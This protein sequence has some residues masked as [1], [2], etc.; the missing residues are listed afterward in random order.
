MLHQKRIDRPLETWGQVPFGYSRLFSL[1]KVSLYSPGNAG[2][3]VLHRAKKCKRYPGM[4][5]ALHPRKNPEKPGD[6]RHDKLPKEEQ[7]EKDEKQ[8]VAFDPILY[9]LEMRRD[10][11]K[12]D[13]GAVERRDRNEIEN[14][15]AYVR[16]D[17]KHGNFKKRGRN[18]G[19][20]SPIADDKGKKECD[21]KVRQG[22][23]DRD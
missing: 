22:P 17:D 5:D 7:Q 10:E 9:M 4:E 21:A 3:T 20:P 13:L 2:I 18:E 15:E 8:G 19:G 1:I 11:G 6:E 14:R 12:E 23:R 16:N